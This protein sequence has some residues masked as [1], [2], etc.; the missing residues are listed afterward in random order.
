MLN[1]NYFYIYSILT[2]TL[3]ICTFVCDFLCVDFFRAI[4]TLKNDLDLIYMYVC[5][6]GFFRAINKLKNSR[7]L[8]ADRL[9]D[10]IFNNSDGPAPSGVDEGLPNS[11]LPE[12][13]AI[14]LGHVSTS[15]IL[16]AS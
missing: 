15:V 5:V 13:N 3:Y 2:L 6:R 10:M 8:P 1:H 12:S 16:I 7:T 14:L 4:D 11:R 9:I